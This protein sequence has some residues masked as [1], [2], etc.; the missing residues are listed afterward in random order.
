MAPLQ[1]D[2]RLAEAEAWATAHSDLLKACFKH[3]Q[4]AGEWPALEQLQH[5][6]ELGGNEED[7]ARLA[8]AMPRSLGSVEQQRLVLYVRALAH[9][10]EAAALL[11]DWAKVLGCAYGK[12]K[13]DRSARLTRADALRVLDGDPERARFAALLVL[14]EGWAL[15]SGFGDVDDEWWREITSAVKDARD[16]KGAADLLAARNRTEFP[17]VEPVPE[18]H[19]AP[20]TPRRRGPLKWIWDLINQNIVASLIAAIIPIVISAYLVQSSTGG[21]S[22][23]TSSEGISTTSERSPTSGERGA[24]SG[25]PKQNPRAQIVELTGSWSEEGFVEAIVERNTGIVALYLKS[26]LSATTL[27]DGASAIIFGFQGV[28]QNGDPIALLKTFQAAGFEVDEELQDSFIMDKLTEG[29]LPLIFQT[30]LTP[31]G[32]T[33]GYSGGVFVGSLLFW[34]VQRETDSVPPPVNLPVIEYLVDQGADCKVPLSFLEFTRSSLAGTKPYG[35][36]L[37]MMES[38]A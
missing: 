32:Y 14:R 29:F 11:D 8:F 20:K 23:S 3:F 2:P 7:V 18:T 28:P 31:R 24:R 9:V 25:K 33:G 35:E 37:R 19:P 38:C 26:G 21:G 10:P 12:W 1:A 30:D 36:L 34:I 4:Q 16:E 27:H 17:A 13:G 6:F 15:G 22:P 5:D